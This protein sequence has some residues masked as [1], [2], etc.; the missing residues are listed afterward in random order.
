MNSDVNER[1]YLRLSIQRAM[2]G[3]V[4][5]NLAG[6]SSKLSDNTVSVSAYYFE[7]PSEKDRDLF[8]EITTLVIADFPVDF[9]LSESE[10]LI[11]SAPP[12]GVSWDYLR[13]EADA[14]LRA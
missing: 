8:T 14:L 10:S 13:A 11:S 4:S 5:S 12:R 9:G 7:N 3:N 1:S 6:M 2:V